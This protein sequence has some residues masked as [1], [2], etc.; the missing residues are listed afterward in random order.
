M[1]SFCNF[2]KH[3]SFCTVSEANVLPESNLSKGSVLFQRQ[4]DVSA[5]RPT[6]WCRRNNRR[7]R[8]R[9]HWLGGTHWS[10]LRVPRPKS[11]GPIPRWDRVSVHRHALRSE[12][13][14][15]PRQIHHQ[16]VT[17]AGPAKSALGTR[18]RFPRFRADPSACGSR[19]QRTG[20]QT[21]ASE[22]QR[23]I[24][25][26]EMKKMT[27]NDEKACCPCCP[28]RKFTKYDK[29][30]SIQAMKNRSL[31]STGTNCTNERYNIYIISLE[32]QLK[33]CV[34]WKNDQNPLWSSL[35]H[36]GSCCETPILHVRDVIPRSMEFWKFGRSIRGRVTQTHQQ[37]TADLCSLSPDC[38]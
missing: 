27:K 16:G 36:D 38:A 11:V 20:S 14:A 7:C 3:C 6:S 31:Q 37:S 9:S 18:G 1:E 17:I 35:I 23:N 4:W 15:V 2:C 34:V 26:A 25:V 13:K 30:K 32:K 24:N 12:T 28:E 19:R 33:N 8:L 10:S 29:I 21:E 5:A 22:H